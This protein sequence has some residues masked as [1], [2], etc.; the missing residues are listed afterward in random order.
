VA[1][2]G[3][4]VGVAG[5]G[6]GRHGGGQVS[7]PGGRPLVS[8]TGCLLP[9]TVGFVG[10]CWTSWCGDRRQG[11]AGLRLGRFCEGRKGGRT[12]S[13]TTERLV[14]AEGSSAED[15]QN[16]PGRISPPG[17]AGPRFTGPASFQKPIANSVFRPSSEEGS[18]ACVRRC[19]LRLRRPR[20]PRR[21]QLYPAAVLILRVRFFGRPG[22][23]CLVRGFR[24]PGSSWAHLASILAPKFLTRRHTPPGTRDPGSW[25]RRHFMCR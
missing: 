11:L 5:R 14:G 18:H 7:D 25:G 8:E 4:D 6:P 13:S 19:Q 12:E 9:A 2:G 15:P 21:T 20:H 22:P 3:A 1:G 24:F 10:P 16:G 17:Y 23:G